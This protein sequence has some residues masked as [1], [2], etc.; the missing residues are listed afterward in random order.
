MSLQRGCLSQCGNCVFVIRLWN[1]QCICFGCFDRTWS[2]HLHCH[3]RTS[4]AGTFN[5]TTQ[6]DGQWVHVA[7]LGKWSMW[8][9]RSKD[10]SCDWN[11]LLKNGE[12]RSSIQNNCCWVVPIISSV[13]PVI[14]CLTIRSNPCLTLNNDD[15]AGIARRFH[16]SGKMFLGVKH[17]SSVEQHI[18]GMS[19]KLFSYNDLLV[20]CRHHVRTSTQFLVLFLDNF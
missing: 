12:S 3:N 1:C 16:S 5:N 4:I 7:T 9:S 14:T 17:V 15:V 19:N 10:L 2:F 20:C 13:F 6:F 8:Q 11:I 18:D